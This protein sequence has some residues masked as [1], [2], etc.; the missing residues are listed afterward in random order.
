[1]RS[2]PR[3]AAPFFFALAAIRTVPSGG[4]SRCV[5][6]RRSAACVASVADADASVLR[7]SIHFERSVRP[8]L[9]TPGRTQNVELPSG[10]SLASLHAVLA[11]RLVADPTV[12]RLLHGKRAITSDEDLRHLLQIAA[13]RDVEPA[14]RVIEPAEPGALPPAPPTPTTV[15]SEAELPTETLQMVSFYAFHK[16]ASSEARVASL[17]A[18]LDELLDELGALGSIY[19][20]SEGINGQ[21]SVPLSRLE[22][23]RDGLRAEPELAS[24]KVNCGE[25]VEPST[26]P[27]RK[28]VVKARRQI[29]TDGLERPLDWQRAGEDVPPEAWDAALQEEGALLLDCR[30]GYESDVGTFVLNGGGGAQAEAADTAEPASADEVAAE[31]LGTETF[32]Q[33]WDVLRQRLASVPK[34]APILTYCTGGIR[35]V[36]VNAFLEQ[37]LGFSNT[38]K[39]Q[40]GIV[41]YLRHKRMQ[42]PRQGGP[43]P[44]GDAPSSSAWRGANFVFDRRTLVGES[45]E[46]EESLNVEAEDD[47]E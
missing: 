47:D 26:R 25:R 11:P 4:I 24:L 27:F 28:R 17:V 7:L 39:L 44:E 8:Y 2:H 46:A 35:C 12:F 5:A 14:L 16:E 19:V 41:G 1:M 18:T 10:A 31:P 23:L 22:G 32:A 13:E 3:Q 20:A 38:K 34:D 15:V 36:K 9:V 45:L 33:S 30:N 6:F 40:H 29:L 43:A 37:E 42:E 21:V